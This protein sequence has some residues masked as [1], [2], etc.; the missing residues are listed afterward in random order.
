MSVKPVTIPVKTLA[1]SI[2]STGSSFT[3][4]NIIG[5]NGEN[6]TS[7][8][9]GS[10]A[11]G[12]FMSADR[13][14]LELFEFDPATIASSSITIIKRGLDFGGLQTEVTA[15]KR[16]W[17]ANETFVLLGTDTPQFMLQLAGQSNNNLFTGTN[18]FAQVP[19][20]SGGD[21]VGDND[22]ARKAY[23]LAVVL[24]TLTTIDLIVPGTAGE[25]LAAGNGVY[26]DT[27]DNKWKKWDADTAATV[28][29]V[30]LGIAQGSG[31]N[32]VAI[33][34][35]VLLQ[36]VDTNQSGMTAGQVQYAS[37]T[38]GGFSSS[39]GTTEVTVGVAKSTTSI[40][41]APRFNQM[42]TEDQQDALE[43]T[44]GTP[45]GTNKYV[46]NNDTTGTG[47][48][49]RSSLIQPIRFGG[50]G[51]D[52]A[53]AISSGTTTIDCANA[54]VVVKNYTSISITGTGKL[55]FSNPNTNGTVIILRSQGNV[56]LTSS[57]AP[58]IDA[59]GMGAAGGANTGS[60]SSNT[61]GSAGSDSN[62]YSY[63]KNSKGGAGLFTGGSTGGALEAGV[64]SSTQNLI[65]ARYPH[66]LPGAGGGSGAYYQGGGFPAG[67]SGAGGR[68]GGGLIIE[69]GGAWNFTTAS[70]ISVAGNNGANA[71]GSAGGVGSVN[72]GGGGGGGS[73]FALYNSLTANSGTITI[74]GGTGGSTIYNVS[75]NGSGGA[76]GSGAGG[77]GNNASVG[78]N[79][80]ADGGTGYSL[81][82]NVNLV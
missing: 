64:I 42:I 48:L 43:G 3:L 46:T 12:A 75:T 63:I 5:W 22:L 71:A 36:G 72:G 49:V 80:G 66:V 14:V 32:G 52:G 78:N 74:S 24:G 16:D 79:P 73:F 15:N 61:N 30:L 39:P 56:T 35:G 21:P 69:C 8:N 67:T 23:V 10:Q 47:S 33:T 81:V 77:S 13:T 26:L 28:N 29:N 82:S 40:Y 70:G 7:A 41:F 57:Q 4:N 62:V 6:L 9:F 31:T 45:S 50:D 17:T 55:A 65:F 34:N 25:T 1:A 11:F 51:S 68:G 20:T 60:V 58:M 53:L 37:N 2:L 27:A 44:S 19:T 76:G 18:D 38:A 59:S 54:A